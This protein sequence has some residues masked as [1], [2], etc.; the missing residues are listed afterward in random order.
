[1]SMSSTW[2]SLRRCAWRE[3][4]QDLDGL[5]G[6]LSHGAHGA[7]AGVRQPGYLLRCELANLLVTRR[8]DGCANRLGLQL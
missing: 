4:A 6:L 3:A 5:A 8:A 7:H 1:M 2:S